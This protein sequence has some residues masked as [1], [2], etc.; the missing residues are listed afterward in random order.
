MI[1]FFNRKKGEMPRLE[2]I[3]SV[4]STNEI[5]NKTDELNEN[6]D[7][8]INTV[9]SMH[10]EWNLPREDIYAFQFLNQECEP[11]RPNQL[12]LSGINIIPEEG[13]DFRVT[14]LVR[15]T[16]SKSIKLE[17][18]PLVLINESGDTVAKRIFN[19]VDLGDIPPNSSRP[20]TFH[21]SKEDLLASDLPKTKWKLAFQF[22]SQKKNHKLELEESWKKSLTLESKIQLEEMVK[23]LTPP[24]QG[25]V[26]FMGVQAKQ[27][28]NNSI[29]VT[30]LIRNG[31]DKN[32]HIEKLPL[33][34]TDATGEIVAKGA[35]HLDKLAVRAHTSKP[36][37]FIF[38]DSM[39]VKTNADL[40]KWQVSPLS[41]KK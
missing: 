41:Q 25:E 15:N 17:E 30:L 12:S 20:W 8:K 16:L 31:S 29:H 34:V 2:G 11:L 38:P 24:K 19:L 1:P 39:V 3:E 40:T 36:W 37:T 18:T 28:E 14:A 13:G 9:L 32:I 6:Q 7:E 10:P 5:L 21:F 35:F 23:K 4:H 33:Q 27:I 22:S 26:N